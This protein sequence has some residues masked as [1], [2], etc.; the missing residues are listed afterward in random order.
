MENI[1]TGGSSPGQHSRLSTSS[2]LIVDLKAMSPERWHQFTLLYS[3]LLRFWIRRKSINNHAEDDILQ[4]CLRTVFT[5]IEQF[6]K[7]AAKGTFR[8]WLR[9]IVQRRV[10]DYY[11]LRQEENPATQAFWDSVTTPAQKDPDELVA[12]Q[13]A[14][15]ALEARAL[16]LVKNSTTEKTWQMFW[17]NVVEKVPTAEVARQFG[18][19]S[20]AVRV[21]KAR[22]LQRL[23]DL[24]VDDI[25]FDS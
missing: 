21:A 15:Q 2:S 12:E 3:P 7:K 5:S 10:A 19:S 9:I 22:V 13:K 24:M 25:G 8:G 1:S 17:M 6:E 16:E 23:K 14:M 11:R 4:E 20:A 18:V